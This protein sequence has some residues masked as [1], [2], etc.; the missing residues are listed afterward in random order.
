MSVHWRRGRS[1]SAP[2]ESRACAIA[3]ADYLFDFSPLVSTSAT[4]GEVLQSC[5]KMESADND[6]GRPIGWAAMCVH[7]D[8]CPGVSSSDRLTDYIKVHPHGFPPSQ[9]AAM[10]REL[11]GLKAAR[12]AELE[13]DLRLAQGWRLY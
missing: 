9:M 12:M 3:G 5:K 6:K 8:D 10:S 7:V 4:L 13:F 11:T 2:T 1:S